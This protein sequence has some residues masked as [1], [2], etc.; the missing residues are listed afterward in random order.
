[1]ELN[2]GYLLCLLSIISALISGY[3]LSFETGHTVSIAVIF[4]LISFLSVRRS[5]KITRRKGRDQNM[6]TVLINTNIL[7][8]LILILSILLL[9][10]I[11]KDFGLIILGSVAFTEMLRL[12]S[13][14]R[15]NRNFEPDFGRESRVL[16]VIISMIGYLFNPYYLFYGSLLVFILAAYDSLRLIKEILE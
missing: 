11:P 1:M 3:L 10:I 15:M 13:D 9:P 4:A 12:E 14:M 6:K 5:N 16:I 7:Y 8:E 2:R